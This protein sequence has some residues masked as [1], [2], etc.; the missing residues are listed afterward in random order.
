MCLIS[1]KLGKSFQ[2]YVCN[3]CT[4]D[5]YNQ[6]VSTVNKTK[7]INQSRK[8]IIKVKTE[9]G[10]LSDQ[11]SR[12][13]WWSSWCSPCAGPQDSSSTSPSGWPAATRPPSST[14]LP[15]SSTSVTSPS[16]CPSFM[17]WWTPS[18]TGQGE[19]NNLYLKELWW[20]D[21]PLTKGNKNMSIFLLCLLVVIFFYYFFCNF[22]SET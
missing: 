11:C 16:Y 14:W 22:M 6:S 17:Q 13:C 12:C 4:Q 2:I 9:Q 1:S 15:T 20:I 10:K 21:G 18:F 7:K 3:L 19:N 8:Q 5:Y